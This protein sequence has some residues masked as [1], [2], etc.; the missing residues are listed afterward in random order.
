MKK[1]IKILT[2]VALLAAAILPVQAQ[3]TTSP[4]SRFGFGLLGDNAT[5]AQTQMGGV[6]YAMHSG[7]QVNAMNP[8]AYAATDTLTFLFDMGVD[9]S[10]YSQKEGS[11]SKTDNGG[12]LDYV[13]MQFP[14]GKRMGMSLGLLPYSSVGYS[15]G[16][17]IDNG[18]SSHEGSG[19][20]NQLYL[21]FA[22]RPFGGLSLGFNI[23]YLF[24]TTYNDVYARSNTA[25]TSLFEQVMQVR[26]FHLLFGAQYSQKITPQDEVTV[27]ITYS[28]G[29]DLLGH[30]WIQKYDVG[31]DAA[32]DTLNYIS[33]RKHYSLPDTWGAGVSWT[34]NQLLNIE[35][36]FT[37][38]PWSKAKLY[39]T[40]N[41]TATKYADRYKVAAGVSWRPAMRG[42]YLKRITYRAGF[43]YTRDYVMI[44]DNHVKQYGASI[45]FG[46]PAPGQKTVLNLGFEYLHRQGSPQAL[47]K[48]NYFNIKLGINFNQ[49]WFMQ[50][51]IR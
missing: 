49:L 22:G 31:S 25:A 30:S 15:F 33:L 16:S 17:N 2:A 41:F 34:H 6:G 38:Q 50:S 46:F 8:A 51:K 12:G 7:R 28:P 32:P 29:K 44:G 42:A 21:G 36:D 3:Q 18:S 1:R 37:S 40:D 5:S 13:T 24:G 20:L 48:E 26:D 45:G 10:W 11:V 35:V 43:N 9:F 14:I 19:G 27:G 4:Y 39:N 23:S 47:V